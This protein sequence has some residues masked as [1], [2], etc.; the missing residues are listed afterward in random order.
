MWHTSHTLQKRELLVLTIVWEND[1]LSEME[2]KYLNTHSGPGICCIFPFVHSPCHFQN[3]TKANFL[4]KYIFCFRSCF[5]PL[6]SARFIYY[7]FTIFFFHGHYLSFWRKEI[8][9]LCKGALDHS[10]N[11]VS[12][13]CFLPPLCHLLIAII[14]K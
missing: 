5:Q 3:L 9:Q 4:R 14:H 8:W 1:L 6:V 2:S 11:S 7:V 12:L 10:K 13:R